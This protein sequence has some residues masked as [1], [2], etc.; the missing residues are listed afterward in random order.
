MILYHEVS[1]LYSRFQTHTGQ[2][3]KE[4]VRPDGSVEGTYG[5]VDP[6][7][8]LRYVHLSNC[9]SNVHKLMYS[10]EMNLKGQVNL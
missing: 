5:W 2:Y 3:R 9:L 4:S 6:N 8:V 10:T 7:G 1:N